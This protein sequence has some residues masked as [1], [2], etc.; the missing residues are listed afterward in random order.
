MSNIPVIIQEHILNVYKIYKQK[1]MK[2]LQ[3]YNSSYLR[4]PETKLVSEFNLFKVVTGI[5]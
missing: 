3:I 1:A 4:R 2:P 5:Q